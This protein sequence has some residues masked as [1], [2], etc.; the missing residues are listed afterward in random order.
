M[1]E[2]VYLKEKKRKII[3][4]KCSSFSTPPYPRHGVELMGAESLQS[5]TLTGPPARGASNTSSMRLTLNK[6]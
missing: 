4:A 5:P 1:F 6:G 3:Q 2:H